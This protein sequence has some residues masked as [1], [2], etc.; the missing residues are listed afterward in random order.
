MSGTGWNAELY[1]GGHSFVWKLAEEV[2][3]LLDPA[4]DERIVDLGCGTGHLAHLISQ[5]GAEVVGVDASETMIAKAREAYPGLTF[6]VADGA[7]FDVGRDF[8]AVFSNAALHWMRDQKRVFQRVHAHLRPGG[9]FVFEMGGAG[10]LARIAGAIGE[11]LLELGAPLAATG[12]KNHYLGVN[13]AC[14]LLESAGFDVS[15]ATLTRR[16]TPLEGEHGLRRWIE[17]FGGTW[18]AW[19]AESD[20][21][22]FLGRVEDRARAELF[23]DVS[24]VGDYVRLRVRA[25]RR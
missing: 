21:E 16:P 4:P 7:S 24:W 14:S 6:V 19:V 15:S 1:D 5:Q 20:R 10:N 11:S 8:D 17:M 25:T 22:H 23:R 3:R 2:F 13:R 18:L 12:E 9:R